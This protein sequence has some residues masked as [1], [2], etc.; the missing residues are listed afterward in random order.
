MADDEQDDEQNEEDGAAR[1]FSELRA[2][3][4]VMRRAVEGLPAIID[5]LEPPDYAPS[6]GA[7]AK[8]LEAT[9]ARLA[10]IEEHPALKLTPDQYGSAMRR[11]GADVVA[12]AARALRD[13]TD[14]IGRTEQ[15]LA[16]I[17]GQAKDR[18]AQ[19]RA[20]RQALAIGI[21]AGFVLFPIVAGFAPGGSFLSA[22]TT[23]NADR[24]QAGI[25]LMRLGDP[26]GAAT[27]AAAMRL[28]NANAEALRACED[29]AKKVGKEQKC[30]ISL[31]APA[32]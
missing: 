32:Q 4:T 9:T 17:V 29:A 7:I 28:V 20:V 22:W 19:N 1:A 21:A 12:P 25:D 6:F 14:A 24:W 2:E 11:A 13:E 15:R 16:A 26:A 18:Q 5:A 23:G 31:A 10:A 3:V 30:T 8:T 27:L